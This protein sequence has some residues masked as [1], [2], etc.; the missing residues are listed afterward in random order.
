MSKQANPPEPD[1]EVSSWI[2]E[3]PEVWADALE[4]PSTAEIDE[5]VGQV[6]SGAR[7]RRRADETGRR[8]RR[9]VATVALTIIV[10]TG[11]AVGVA[12][13]IRSGQ[14]SRPSEG[15]ACRSAADPRADAIVVEA[16]SDPVGRCRTLWT[17]GELTQPGQAVGEVPPLVA[18]VGASGVIEVYP[19]GSSMCGQLG[20]V[21]ADPSLTPEN[22]AMVALQDRIVELINDQPCV[23]A[24]KAAAIAQ[25]I[26]NESE[27]NGWTVSVR[28]DSENASC[29]KAALDVPTKTI[30][31]VKFP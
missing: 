21:V 14:P 6:V 7:D 30:S 22:Q 8:R 19:G 20:L 26:V 29:A 28:P 18:C 4:S 1:D 31:V 12:A 10:V 5:L 3:H 11:G 25:E 9:L 15:I 17:D 13:L 16:G 23:A 2:R 24:T 27:L